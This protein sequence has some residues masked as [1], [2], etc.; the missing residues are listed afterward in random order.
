MVAR[1]RLNVTSYIHCVSGRLYTVNTWVQLSD[2]ILI[3]R[4]ITHDGMMD[5]SGHC[6][7]NSAPIDVDNSLGINETS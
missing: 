3:L 6:S 1:T 7:D 2:S 4:D 5:F